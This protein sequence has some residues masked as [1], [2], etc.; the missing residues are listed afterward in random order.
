MLVLLKNPPQ[1]EGLH[2]KNLLKQPLDTLNLISDLQ[3]LNQQLKLNSCLLNA[4]PRLRG[5]C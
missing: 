3:K 2:L 4:I 5:Y 1:I